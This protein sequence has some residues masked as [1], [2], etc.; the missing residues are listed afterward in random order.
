MYLK[1]KKRKQTWHL[2][3]WLCKAPSHS[4]HRG[5]EWARDADG[6]QE[7]RDVWRQAEWNGAIS[8]QVTCGVIDVEAEVRNVELSCVLKSEEEINITFIQWQKTENNQEI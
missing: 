8:I 2:K 5:G 7:L 4:D 6:G 1:R 3:V